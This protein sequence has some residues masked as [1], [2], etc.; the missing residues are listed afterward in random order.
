M[1]KL[2]LEGAGYKIDQESKNPY[3]KCMKTTTTVSAKGQVTIPKRLRDRLGLRSGDVLEFTDDGGRLVGRKADI[4]NRVDALYG[5][6]GRG[7][8]TDKLLEAMRGPG[9][10]RRR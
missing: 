9:L 6:L 2:R 3:C 4:G 7:E 1:R 8:R 5:I 10:R